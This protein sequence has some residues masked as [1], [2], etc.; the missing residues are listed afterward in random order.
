MLRYGRREAALLGRE[1]PR[2]SGT[3][4]EHTEYVIV[5]YEREGSVRAEGVASSQRLRDGGVLGAEVALALVPDGPPLA[6]DARPRQAG[7]AR[8][9]PEGPQDGLGRLVGAEQPEVAQLVDRPHGRR[10]E[11]ERLGANPRSQL[12][13]VLD[14][15]GR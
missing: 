1:A 3:E 10:R 14:R 12:C 2:S 8:H 9:V 7:I 4:H 11:P 15:C 5:A 13:D 6:R